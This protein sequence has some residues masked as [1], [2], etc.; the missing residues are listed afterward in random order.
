VNIKNEIENFISNSKIENE[1][2]Y[3]PAG[4]ID[5]P[6]NLIYIDNKIV[7]EYNL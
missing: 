7:L 4:S 6:K 1:H 5:Y 2:K 3:E